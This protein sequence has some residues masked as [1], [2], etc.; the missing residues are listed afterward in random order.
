[1]RRYDDRYTQDRRR[2][3]LALRLIGHEV[4]TQTISRMT[5]LGDKRI[6]ALYRTYYRDASEQTRRHRGPAPQ[7]PNRLLES[8]SLRSEAAAVGGLLMLLDLTTRKSQLQSQ[9]TTG[10]AAGE[11]LCRAFELYHALVPQPQ[12]DLEHM[13]LLA[14][15]LSRADAIAIGQCEHCSAAILIDLGE[16]GRRVCA[17]CR[18]DSRSGASKHNQAQSNGGEH[19]RPSSAS[20]REIVLPGYQQSLFEFELSAENSHERVVGSK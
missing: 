3:A 5:G 15:S 19:E 13:I 16:V 14:A 2:H 11:R 4:R 10:L 12:I 8:A 17:H 9:L 20:V 6:R 7:R 1:M 18:R